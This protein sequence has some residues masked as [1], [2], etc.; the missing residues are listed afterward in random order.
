MN[1]PHVLGDACPGCD[2]AEHP[3]SLP[4]TVEPDANDSLRAEYRCP[5]GHTWKTWWDRQSA[6]WPLTRSAAA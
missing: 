2:P 1:D 4:V 6:E 3:A 5:R